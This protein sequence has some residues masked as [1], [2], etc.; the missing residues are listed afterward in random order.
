MLLDRLR[1]ISARLAVVPTPVPHD[2]IF[3]SS[4]AELRDWLDENHATAAELW[5]GYR[6]K[7]SGL[8][9]VTWEQ[10]VDECL[11][12]GWIDGVRIRVDG[13]SAQRLTP[14]R[15]GSNW[16]AR[17]VG[18]V[19]A[20]RREG[21]MRP[22]GE[23]AFAKR[24]EDRTATN[25]FDAGLALDGDAEASLQANR[26]AWAFWEAQP[27]G[28]RRQATHWVMSAKR[29]ETRARR[30]AQLVADS[31]ANKR[32]GVLAPQPRRGAGRCHQR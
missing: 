30:L 1:L 26:G 9:S 4:P 17:N 10:V 19:E 23:A 31:A 8:P 15:D 2:I 24:R 20:L 32:I 5:L 25:S 13:G 28:Y 22:A 29:P 7:A 6:P 14:R 12:Y 27:N 21:L 18:R 11:C 16:S 3:F